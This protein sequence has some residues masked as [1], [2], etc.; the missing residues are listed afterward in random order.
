MSQVLFK[1]IM[2][3]TAE[4]VE[5]VM[6]TEE[7]KGVPDLEFQLRLVVEELVSNVVN[8][9]T[10]EK[11]TINITHPE[12]MLRITIIDEGIP[13]DP[14]KKDNPD[15]TLSAE[16]RKIGGLGIFLVREMMDRVTY[17]YENN[18]NIL[19]IEKDL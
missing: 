18:T 10:S 1:P 2:E 7:I 17:Q 16:D 14:L 15:I 6:E 3:R 9:S 19:T 13:F 5:A 11:I 12:K 4:I 8:Y